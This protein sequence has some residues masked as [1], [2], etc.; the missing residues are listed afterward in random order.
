M[1]TILDYIIARVH[2]AM[3]TVPDDV[4]PRVHIAMT[5]VPAVTCVTVQKQNGHNA[6]EPHVL[7]SQ[8]LD[9]DF[10]LVACRADFIENARL[11]IFET[12][13]R[14]HQCISIRWAISGVE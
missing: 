6:L 8:V 1:T 13:C 14:I 12:F 3:T 7:I 11:S 4:I 10:F 2:I 5:T 9:N